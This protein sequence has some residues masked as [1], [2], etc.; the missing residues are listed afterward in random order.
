MASYF[1]LAGIFAYFG[2][3]AETVTIFACMII[4]DFLLGIAESKINNIPIESEK[5][6]NG[7]IRKIAMFVL[8]FIVVAVVK[9]AGLEE[10]GGFMTHAIMGILIASEGYSVIGHI[11]NINTGKHL[12]E[13]DVLSALIEK[14][15]GLFKGK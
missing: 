7:V 14:V 12:P 6:R 10:A 15:A 5:M 3:N 11:Y 2:L 4:V 1:S 8:P 13:N 9:G